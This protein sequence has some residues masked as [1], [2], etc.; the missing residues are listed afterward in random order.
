[1]L[2]IVIQLLSLLSGLLVNFG[3]PALYGLESYGLFIKANILVFVAQK[4]VDIVNEPLLSRVDSRYVLVMALFTAF[5]MLCV[6]AIADVWFQIGNLILLLTMLLTSC[7][8][9]AMYSLANRRDVLIYLCIYIAL[10]S[11]LAL[12]PIC[13]GALLPIVEVMIWTNAIAGMGAICFLVLLGSK[14]PTGSDL[15]DTVKLG[16]S[17]LP[18]M[19]SVTLVFNLVTNILPFLLSKIL[20][21]KDLGA[22]KVTTSLVQSATSI[23][24]VNTKAIFLAFMS[25]NYDAAILVPLVRLSLLYFT[26]AG[27][28]VELGS[29]FFLTDA[30]LFLNMMPMLPVLFWAMLMERFLLANNMYAPVLLA[31]YVV[32]AVVLF[33]TFFVGTLDQALLLYA[34]GLTG[35]A[36]CLL[37]ACGRHVQ[38]GAMSWVLIISLVGIWLQMATGLPLNLASATIMTFLSLKIFGLRKSDAFIL[39]I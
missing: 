7:C 17:S 21:P 20:L 6:F 24:P 9:L 23:F 3:V 27:F 39:R 19:F 16:L 22:F 4:I 13:F 31:N 38:K 15:L 25:K 32:S 28:F 10:F 37:S 12:V 14:I 26:L 36:M 8:S 30:R 2:N 35:Y 29:Y 33:A 1:M 18:K 5:I 11:I 34:V